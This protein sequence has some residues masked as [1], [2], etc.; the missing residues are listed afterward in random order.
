MI[1]SYN[2]PVVKLIRNKRLKDRLLH[3]KLIKF[4]LA[5]EQF[6]ITAVA[7]CD[8]LSNNRKLIT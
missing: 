2:N 4:T 7:A 6:V 8:R 1:V 5:S 3:I